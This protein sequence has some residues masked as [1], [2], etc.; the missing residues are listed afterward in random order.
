M[1]SFTY[2]K[3]ERNF[4]KIAAFLNVSQNL[5]N[6]QSPN[7]IMKMIEAADDDKMIEVHHFGMDPLSVERI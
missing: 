1:A 2:S 4:K 5:L 3:K 6:R 7:L